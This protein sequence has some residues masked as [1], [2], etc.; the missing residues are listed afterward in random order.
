VSSGSG[1]QETVDGDINTTNAFMI[2]VRHLWLSA[3]V[4]IIY[5]LYRVNPNA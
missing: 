3:S 4:G 2:H 5:L 1:R